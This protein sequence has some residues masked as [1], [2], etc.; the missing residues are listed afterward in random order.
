MES[1]AMTE[2]QLSPLTVPSSIQD[3]RDALD[4]R[5]FPTVGLWNRLEGRPRTTD[6]D[7]ALR[8]EVRDA[9][10]MLSR[11]WQLGEFRASDAGSP[12]T[13]TYSVAVT[14]LTRYRPGPGGA[15]TELPLDR[16]LEA[17]AERRAVPFARGA[18]PISFD[19]RLAIGRRWLKLLGTEPGLWTYR[20]NYVAAFPIALPDPD[21]DE[22]TPRVAHPEVW[23]TMQAVSGRR[24]DGYSLYRQI[25][26]GRKAYD[27]VSGIFQMHHDELTELGKKLVGWFDGLIDQ[28]AGMTAEKPHGDAAWDPRRLEHRFSVAASAPGGGEKVLTAQGVP[29]RGA[30]LARVLRRPERPARRHRPADGA[31]QQD[32]LPGAGAVLRHAAAPVVGA[33]GRSDELRRRNARTAPTWRG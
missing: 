26:A 22:D 10:W 1:R 17:V 25:K 4:K 24:M 19:L 31:D 33:G 28:P 7:R 29:R 16:P 21:D 11:Q 9:L 27:G 23:S 18:D 8:A 14:S 2:L 30:G 20:D 5:K 15:V 3:L 13:V 6:F 32:R 12:V